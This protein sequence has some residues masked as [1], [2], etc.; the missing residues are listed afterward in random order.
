MTYTTEVNTVVHII[1]SAD[2]P[3]II[4]SVDYS[5]YASTEPCIPNKATEL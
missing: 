2:I 1:L 4:D 5:V 3:A